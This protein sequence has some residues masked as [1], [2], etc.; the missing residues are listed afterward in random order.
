MDSQ[1]PLVSIECI[2]YN[3]KDYIRRCLDGFVSQITNFRF[4]A[5]VHDD[6]STDG[7]SEIVKEYAEKYP[8]II[9]PIFEKEN[10][11]SKHDGSLRRIVE[12]ACIGKYIAFCEGDDFWTDPYKLQKQVDIL[13]HNPDVGLVH[14]NFKYVDL[15]G[16][17][18]SS[19]SISTAYRERMPSK[20]QGYIYGRLFNSSSSILTCT[21]VC[22]SQFV[23]MRIGSLDHGIF[24]TAAMKNQIVYID[25]YTSSYRVNP[26]GMMISLSSVVEKGLLDTITIHMFNYY[27]GDLRDINSYYFTNKEL[28][29]EVDLF[30]AKY[31]LHCI[32][33]GC[34]KHI[35]K[36]IMRCFL[37][38]FRLLFNTPVLMIKWSLRKV[39]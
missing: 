39:K 17:E 24:M 15:E 19:S 23:K 29:N 8:N 34:D 7:T 6:A 28:Q 37:K 25:D 9:K 10:Q 12:S 32:K 20:S 11:F 33:Y 13:E 27:L 4:E 21:V 3:H 18:I 26:K 2:T 22:K 36:K 31:M 35:L 5:I 1:S 38:H 14:T 16:R 30:F